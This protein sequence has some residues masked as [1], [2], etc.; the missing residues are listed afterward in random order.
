LEQ[1][2]NE[3]TDA[4]AKEKVPRRAPMMALDLDCNFVFSA[5]VLLGL[6]PFRYRGTAANP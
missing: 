4:P 3:D 2:P 5:P 6:F 1:R